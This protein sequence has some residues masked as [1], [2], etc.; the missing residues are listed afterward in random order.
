MFQRSLL[1]LVLN[2]PLLQ[3]KCSSV[4]PVSVSELTACC[5][6]WGRLSL[7]RQTAVDLSLMNARALWA[8]L[9]SCVLRP[10]C[11]ESTC[12]SDSSVVMF[13]VTGSSTDISED[14]EKDFDLDMTEEEVQLALSK[15]EVSGEVSRGEV[16]T[17]IGKKVAPRNHQQ[18]LG[19]ML[20]E[21]CCWQVLP[22]GGEE[23][24]Q[25][26][27]GR[28]P[29]LELHFQ[30]LYWSQG[31]AA[32]CSETWLLLA[33]KGSAAAGSCL[34]RVARRRLLKGVTCSLRTQ[35]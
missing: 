28:I 29:L 14:W 35:A 12:S 22:L 27:R 2:Q 15:V 7:L 33:W 13:V 6:E 10:E 21:F 25:Y 20:H 31:C 16:L 26:L 30:S 17:Q 9:G 18:L 32:H 11:L 5:W 34:P 4:H 19:V 23:S 1:P 24:L 8:C 3:G